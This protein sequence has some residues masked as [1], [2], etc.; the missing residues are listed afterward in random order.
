MMLTIII[1]DLSKDQYACEVP[2][3]TLVSTIAT[4]FSE[5]MGWSTR[6]P[7]VVVELVTGRGRQERT[8]QLKGEKSLK[9]EK[10]HDR[11]VLR[12]FVKSENNLFLDLHAEVDGTTI[13]L[14]KKNE[15]EVGESIKRIINNHS[16]AEIERFIS[17]IVKLWPSKEPKTIDLD[18]IGF[19]YIGKGA[20][21]RQGL[22][23]NFKIKEILIWATNKF[24][25]HFGEEYDLD[26]GQVL[27][28]E[29]GTELW[30]EA[31]L[32]Q[33]YLPEKAT[34]ILG[35]K[36]DIEELTIYRDQ[37]SIIPNEIIL[38]GKQ[39]VHSY[40]LK[41]TVRQANGRKKER[42]NIDTLESIK[43][44]LRKAIT[45][46]QLRKAFELFMKIPLEE[47]LSLQL[48]AL[49]ARYNT[50]INDKRMG[51]I[52]A[53]KAKR[54]LNVIISALLEIVTELD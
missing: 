5:M 18:I 38:L 4:D 31:S 20:F 24:S 48:A 52:T 14:P 42:D 26:E 16:P 7:Q 2:A 29:T 23:S 45:R 51:V 22:P 44:E 50:C 1:E 43:E 19:S 15:E 37:L 49:Q 3:D 36:E 17:S 46:N 40:C 11:G 25:P 21:V 6:G 54:E 32:S 33:V 39:A 27:C 47:G 12:I 53:G 34:L 9:E 10:V 13:N 30:R 35:T 28:K 8:R 41:L